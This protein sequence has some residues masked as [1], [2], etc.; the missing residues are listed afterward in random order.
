MEG[1]EHLPEVQA[2]ADAG[3]CA[4]CFSQRDAWALAAELGR[5]IQA[6][7]IRYY[8]DILGISHT[9]HITKE[10]VR[11]KFIQATRQYE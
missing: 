7:E 1:Q 8:R 10:T 11:N 4:F 2:K 9:E 6:I 5:I 3:P